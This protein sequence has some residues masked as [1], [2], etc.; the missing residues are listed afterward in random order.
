MR[1]MLQRSWAFV[2]THRRGLVG[3]GL[4]GAVLLGVLVWPEVADARVGGGQSYGRGRGGGGGLG[5]GGGGGGEVDLVFLLLHLCIRY[6]AIGVPLTLAV[7]GFLVAR[8]VWYRG[9]DHRVHRTRGRLPGHGP[10]AGAAG[11]GAS[12]L[13][14]RVGG[15][16]RPVPG[17]ERLR[18]DDPGFSLPVL[19]DY[20]VLVHRR[21]HEAIGNQAWAALAP[22]VAEAAR[23]KLLAAHADVEQV[24]EVV[25]GGVS[26]T[27]VE[28]RAEH[29]HLY[30]QLES[31]RTER[32]AGGSSRR[33]QVRE[34]WTLRRAHGV[35]SQGP[36]SV[37]RLGC[38]SCGASIEVTPMGA[39]RNCDTPITAGQLTWQAVFVAV[40]SRVR[41][42][43]PEVG[44]TDG[45]NESSVLVPI[46]HDPNLAAGLRGLQ[47]R[48]P[49][50]D[51][52]AFGKRVELVYHSLQE[53]WSQAEWDQA[54]PFVTDRMYQTLRFWVERYARHGLRNRL[55]DVQI[56][57]VRMVKV[58]LDAWYEAITVRLWGSMKDAIV[59]VSDGKV[60]GGNPRVARKFSEYWTFL[61][62]AG[63]EAGTRGDAPGCPSCGA[64]LDRVNQAG[65]CNYCG[66]KITTGQFDWV[67]ARIE[68]PEAYRG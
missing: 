41:A 61:R 27:K 6:P 59:Q 29:D 62:A 53:A 1:A 17:L 20:V 42:V 35:A 51:P 50:F 68:Q 21:A 46:V 23:E 26:L 52:A 67:L 7:G 43:V 32:L 33:V 65:I 10:G 60:I 3:A 37:E 45:G 12:D 63:G 54:R 22:F 4:A 11:L 28:R 44:W 24:T 57:R 25:V 34:Q 38:P 16:P 31:T 66:S 18:Q 49:E 30:V 15:R 5:G 19:Y 47:G 2:L 40:Q 14:E 9:D 58:E 55:E 64:P 8:A 48:H 13:G 36:E 56:N 39:C